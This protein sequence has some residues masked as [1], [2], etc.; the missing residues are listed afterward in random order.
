MSQEIHTEENEYEQAARDG[1]WK[2]A[3]HCKF[4]IMGQDGKLYCSFH[5][6]EARSEILERL[7]SQTFEDIGLNDAPDSEVGK[8]NLVTGCSVEECP[9]FSS[10]FVNR[11]RSE[12]R[13]EERVSR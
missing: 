11:L 12:P 10:R 5:Y 8:G 1:G 13:P 9:S 7:G 4:V 6:N 3:P 2:K